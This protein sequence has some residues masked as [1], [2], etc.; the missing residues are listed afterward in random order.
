MEN[1]YNLIVKA[2]QN[3]KAFHIAH[4]GIGG[5]GQK[6]LS[7]ACGS[8]VTTWGGRDTL[9][10]SKRDFKRESITCKKCLKAYD[11]AQEAK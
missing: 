6:Y 1:T 5:H 10:I 9:F 7:S 3:G 11:K 2:G 4:E 8:G